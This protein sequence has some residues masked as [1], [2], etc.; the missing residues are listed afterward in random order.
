MSP[1]L[2]STGKA[3]GRSLSDDA[4]ARRYDTGVISGALPFINETFESVRE[5]PTLQETIVAA[6]VAGAVVGA[7]TGGPLADSIGRR[8]ALLFGDAFF[9]G[10]AVLMGIAPGPLVLI[11]G[12]VAVGIGVGIASMAVP[13]YIAEAAP[14]SIRASL[15]AVNTLLITVG[16]FAS[17]VVNYFLAGVPHTWRWMLGV[18]GI[19]ALIQ[20][21]GLRT[22]PESPRWLA[23]VGKEDKAKEAIVSTRRTMDE[24]R[25]ELNEV[26]EVADDSRRGASRNIV[27]KLRSLMA[28]PEVRLELGLGLGLQALQQ[29]VAINTVMYYTPTILQ[30]AGLGARNALL[31]SLLPAGVN[32]VFSLIGML[33]IDRCG[34]RPLLLASLFGCAVGLAVLGG[35]FSKAAHD[36]IPVIHG[37]LPEGVSPCPDTLSSASPPQTCSDCLSRGCGFCHPERPFYQ[38]QAPGYCMAPVEESACL[39]EVGRLFKETETME[40]DDEV[41]RSNHGLSSLVGLML[42]LAFFAPGMAHIPWAVNAEIYPEDARGIG[43]AAATTVNWLANLLVAQTFLTLIEALGTAWTFWLFGIIAVIGLLVYSIMLPETNGLSLEDVQEVFRARIR[44]HGS[45]PLRFSRQ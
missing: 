38:R 36:P 24:A 18:A 5:S 23:W 41:C 6:A 20:A 9:V 28:R 21:I 11:L 31:T 8:G 33:I 16:Q 40:F 15:V 44:R 13:I 37:P 4:R 3:R 39:D 34:R 1:S 19:P 26:E 30:L 25:Q 45:E 43:A 27:A 12:R 29:L 2:C 10:G 17:F 22:L 35:S 42:F 14:P 32:S 7:A